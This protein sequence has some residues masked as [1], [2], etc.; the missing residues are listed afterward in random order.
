MMV[1]G[2]NKVRF[3]IRV[4]RPVDVSF[5]EHLR[6]FGEIQ[7]ENEFKKIINHISHVGAVQG[8][9]FETD[10][11]RHRDLPENVHMLYHGTT[12]A[13]WEKI[14]SDPRGLV[15]S[16][17]GSGRTESYFSSRAPWDTGVTCVGDIPGYRFT[18][19]VTVVYNRKKAELKGCKF[20]LAISDAILTRSAVPA[21][22]AE[23]VIRNYDKKQ[24]WP[25]TATK[26]ATHANSAAS[27]SMTSGERQGETSATSSAPAAPIV[28]EVLQ[29]EVVFAEEFPHQSYHKIASRFGLWI[30]SEAFRGPALLQATEFSS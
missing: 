24:L 27:S 7:L 30:H 6:N 18:S 9:T 5:F 4:T 19:E 29:Q 25:R 20:M 28:N 12:E 11:S 3:Q 10:L 26:E 21:S 13:A 16:G 2:S 1:L 22:S 8:H 14:I 23:A 15:P 17:N